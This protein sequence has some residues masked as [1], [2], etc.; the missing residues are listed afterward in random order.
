MVAEEQRELQR[1]RPFDIIRHLRLDDLR[2]TW[3]P[4]RSTRQEQNGYF[5][6]TLDRE[7]G[8]VR[9]NVRNTHGNIHRFTVYAKA[10]FRDPYGIFEN[11]HDDQQGFGWRYVVDPN[12][13]EAVVRV[14]EVLESSAQH[15]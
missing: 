15:T 3:A 7:F 9:F 11:F 2:I 4:S 13:A 6:S 12:D 8:F 14:I 1:D 10:P 5:L